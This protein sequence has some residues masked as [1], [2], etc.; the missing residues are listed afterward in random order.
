MLMILR[1]SFSSL[2]QKTLLMLFNLELGKLDEIFEESVVE[3]L[4]TGDRAS[5]RESFYYD[6]GDV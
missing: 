1:L 5:L 2:C 3:L 6:F 4:L